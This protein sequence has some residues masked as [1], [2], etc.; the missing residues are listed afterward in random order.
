MRGV[1]FTFYGSTEP[2]TK[3]G[4][5]YPFLVP[6][7]HRYRFGL[8]KQ[9]EEAKVFHAHVMSANYDPNDKQYT[10]QLKAAAVLSCNGT[11]RLL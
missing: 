6:G 7:Q 11:S 2:G 3:E 4:S 1:V 8:H 10:N 5:K 9:S